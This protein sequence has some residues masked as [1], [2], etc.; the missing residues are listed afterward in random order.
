MSRYTTV[1]AAIEGFAYLS[2]GIVPVMLVGQSV[3]LS[4]AS[5]FCIWILG[6]LAYKF[7]KYTELSRFLTMVARHYFLLAVPGKVL[8]ALYFPHM[9][10]GLLDVPEWAFQRYLPLALLTYLS[11][12]IG[13]YAALMLLAF[14]RSFRTMA[15]S[16][17]PVQSEAV[18]GH[19]VKTSSSKRQIRTLFL[20]SLTAILL[21]VILIQVL[22][23][24]KPGVVPQSIGFP[25]LTGF[26]NSLAIHGALWLTL[27]LIMKA[28]QL[29]G[30]IP[31]L[32]LLPAFA[33]IL[34][35]LTNGYKF[36]LISAAIIL[37]IIQ[38]RGCKPGIFEKL[39]I[40]VGRLGRALLLICG[41]VMYPV[42]DI[43][44]DLMA[45]G[46]AVD[47]LE[48][49]STALGSMTTELAFLP[50]TEILRRINGL[51]AFIISHYFLGDTSYE[52][53]VLWGTRVVEDLRFSV[54]G[55]R[56][57]DVVS[58]LGSTIFNPA[59]RLG[60]QPYVAI[61]LFLA[62][63]FFAL[64]AELFFQIFRK[65]KP[66]SELML[67]FFAIEYSRLFFSAG[68]LVG[69]LKILLVYL[70]MAYFWYL[71]TRLTINL[72]SRRRSG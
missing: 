20:L 71:W 55:F 52:W 58:A 72:T 30:K 64:T 19:R 3:F 66:L 12:A 45:D 53:T 47:L 17:H 57:G 10:T 6:V 11:G 46:V 22:D 31:Y 43:Y 7:T 28:S 23:F 15:E 29:N 34:L 2:L 8:L 61:V 56:V 48:L 42:I 24:A 65:D 4:C 67:G 41:I 32:Y 60:G 21:K 49:A 33:N 39:P 40:P 18:V 50:M 44:S 62:T 59:I 35:D 70:A 13:A 25:G 54:Y 26:L 51:D 9:T 5:L 14:L 69:N 68:D 27:M 63:T 38:A 1:F 36:S 37:M 16:R